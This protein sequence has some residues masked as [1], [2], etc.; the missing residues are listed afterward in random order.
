MVPS[1]SSPAGEFQVLLSVLSVALTSG[2]FID[3]FLRVD[4]TYTPLY[5]KNCFHLFN[6]FFYVH[7]L[8][9]KEK[10]NESL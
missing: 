10:V 8:L 4:Q 2:I 3:L 7:F 1:K 9:N 6:S 5:P